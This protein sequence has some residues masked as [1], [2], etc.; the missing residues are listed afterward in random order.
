M[1]LFNFFKSNKMDFY[2][3]SGQDQFAYNLSGLNGFYLEIGAHHPIVNSNTVNKGS[4]SKFRPTLFVN[5]MFY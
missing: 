1:R 4:S 5:R 3:Q 2:S